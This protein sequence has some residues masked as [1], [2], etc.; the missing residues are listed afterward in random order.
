MT[1]I[2][3]Y[4]LVA[5][6]ILFLSAKIGYSLNLI[7]KPNNR[8]IHTRPIAYTGGIA[9]SIILLLAIKLFDVDKSLNLIIS[10][11]FLISCIGL[12]DDKY[13]LKVG[14]KLSLQIVPIFFLVVFE[15]L[16]L[17]DFGYY[18][19]FH[20]DLGAFT[21]PFTFVCVLFLI[22]SFN[23]FDGIDGT[24]GISSVSVLLILMFLIPIQNFQFFLL[25]IMIPTLI[26]L[27]FNFS[28]L[29]FPKLF[30]GDSGSL[31]FGF[32]ISFILIYAAK[33][34]LTHPI[35]LAWSVAIFVYEFL[36]INIIRLKNKKNLFLPGQDHLHHILFSKYRSFI[37]TNFFIFTL[38]I[39]FFIIGYSIFFIFNPLASLAL[40]IF[41]FI[42]YFILRNKYS[43]IKIKI[44][45][46]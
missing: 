13:N 29:N 11:S 15:S 14:S 35:L 30:L 27:F 33:Y 2:I 43:K 38:N 4:S 3:I 7:D 16:S 19:Y 8:K 26:F 22:N 34:N 31:L 41:S 21:I 12:I 24:L 42:A 40:F 23:Y 39:I 25:L 45:I 6:F 9:I 5:F 32:L 28:L 36:S 10:I 46:R 37:I 17:E 1:Y 44:K 18:Y 20:T